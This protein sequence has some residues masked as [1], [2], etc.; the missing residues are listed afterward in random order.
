MV[1]SIQFLLF[2]TIFIFFY[3]F[4]VTVGAPTFLPEEAQ[5]ELEEMY[6]PTEPAEIE[7]VPEEVNW[8]D[9]IVGFLN[10]VYNFFRLIYNAIKTFWILLKFS[11][12]IRWV[13]LIIIIPYSI[14]LLY[15]LLQLIPFVGG[16]K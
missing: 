9:R 12:T 16:G 11:S 4:V 10:A 5:R 7:E 13:S 15:I 8:F 2:Y 14:V 1:T 6:V 3:V